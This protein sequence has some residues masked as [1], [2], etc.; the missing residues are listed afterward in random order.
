M[1]GAAADRP[2]VSTLPARKPPLPSSNWTFI[3]PGGLAIVWTVMSCPALTR[4]SQ[5]SP[6]PPAARLL[7]TTAE[8]AP[9]AKVMRAEPPGGGPALTVGGGAVGGAAVGGAAVAAPA[10]VAEGAAVMT[11][12][13]ALPAGVALPVAAGTAVATV[14]VAAMVVPA[15]VGSVIAVPSGVA[16]PTSSPRP[17][18]ATSNNATTINRKT[19]K[20]LRN[21]LSTPCNYAPTN[22]PRDD[23]VTLEV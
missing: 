22:R 12:G 16:S 1:A 4:N 9:G 6:S 10:T 17:R 8:V 7:L 15:V 11:S 18:Q 21:I 20:P 13:V 3:C 2:T 5:V 19:D 14:E 23:N